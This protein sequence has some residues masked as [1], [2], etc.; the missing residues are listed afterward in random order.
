MRKIL[1]AVAAILLLSG[2]YLD[3]IKSLK[4]D[5]SELKERMAQYENLL[6]VLNKR[7]YIVGY[8]STN[9]GYLISM[10]DG[11]KLNVRNT[12]SFIEIGANGNWYIDGVDTG[13]SAQGEPGKAPEIV[14][15]E[16]GNWW[17]NGVDTQASA[18]GQYGKDASNITAIALD[19]GMMTFTFADGRTLSIQA[20][21]PEIT[22]SQ[23]AE[24]Y[25]ID[26][27]QWFR[28]LPQI[29]N[30]DG[31]SYIWLVNGTEVSKSLEL[32]YVF[33]ETG[34]YTLEFRAK[35]GVGENS[36]TFTLTVEAKTYEN[37]ITQVFD[38]FPA[39][40]QFINSMPAATDQDTDESMRI[41]AETALSSN[42][43]ITLGGY[44]GYVV[45]GFDHTIVNR[46][47]NDF[48]VLGNAYSNWAEPGIVMVSYDAN[49]NGKPDDQWFEIQGSEHQ[50]P[51]TIKNYEI[52]YYKPATEPEDP[53]EPNYIKWTD[54]QGETGYVSKNSF[55]KQSYYPLWK[56]DR[57]TLKGTFLK[58]N[59][60]DQSGQ[61]T[62][63]A[64]PAYEYGYTDNWGNNDA[65]GH[66]DISWAVDKDGESVAL[67]GIDFI[68]VYTANRAEAGWL[69]EV[70]TEV[71]GFKDLNLE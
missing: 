70:S 27:R 23:P 33:A 65:K 59:V 63:W 71:S 55:H 50:K 26:Q 36:E 20:S 62:N 42:N 47:G 22:L 9:G 3:D 48:V 49:G 61:G 30:P 39:P 21:A 53:N 18:T 2:C 19:N 14:I 25:T 41:K 16:N 51:S 8:E 56:G 24:G 10:S 45:M 5:I 12:S 37:K 31:A 44:G 46:E 54:N 11:S 69:G 40:G 13:K 28:L 38:Y 67:Q 66:I 7:L 52:T 15:G 4:E 17:I 1:F 58:S 57:I 43:I 32:H 29:K 64:N 34:S 68:K 60:V 35:N 6:E